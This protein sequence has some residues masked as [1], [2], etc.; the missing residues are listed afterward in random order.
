MIDPTLK[1]ANI[2]IVDDQQANI[3]MLEGFLEMLGYSNLIATTDPREVAALM[4]SFDPDLILLDLMMPFMSGFDV[5]NQIKAIIP[6]D[7]YF[8]ILVLTADITADA[9]QKALTGG[10]KDFLVKPFDLVEVNL[11]IRNL[12]HTRFLAQEYENRNKILDEKVKERTAELEETNKELVVARDKAESSDRMKSAFINNISH[13]IRTPLN[14]IIGFANLLADPGFPVETKQEFIP[15][16]QSSSDRLINTITDYLDISMIV[17]GNMKVSRQ[18]VNV[19]ATLEEFSDKFPQLCEGKPLAFNIVIP[20]NLIEYTIF[21]DP[22]LFEKILLHLL[23][24]AIKFTQEGTI[25]MGFAVEASLIEFYVNDTGSGIGKESHE[26]IFKS[27]TQ[28]NISNTRGHEGSG[29]GLTVIQ[30]LLNLLGGKIRL[31]SEKGQGSAFY[32]TLPYIP[33]PSETE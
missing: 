9:K 14:G 17:S 7:T 13:E 31:E 21:T 28:E 2:L 19:S 30:G 22:V 6:S 12:L 25:T 16:L 11:R 29:L 8:P 27:F 26:V 10:A 24:N 15:L 23:K 4:E 5:M 32:F 20:D 33:V 1:N 18:E 3:D